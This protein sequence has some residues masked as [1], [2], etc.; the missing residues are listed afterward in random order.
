ML[1]P[2]N[3]FFKIDYFI[4]FYSLLITAQSVLILLVTFWTFRKTVKFESVSDIKFKEVGRYVLLVCTANIIQFLCYRM[5]IWFVDYYHSKNDVGLYA[6]ASKISQMW[7]V[8][9]QIFAGF[10]F[11]LAALKHSS[12][13]IYKKTIVKILA[14]TLVTSF[15][16]I[17]LYPVFIKYFV[18]ESYMG[19]F[20]PFVYL[21]PGVILFSV[22]ILLAAKFAGDGNVAVNLV[23]STICFVIVLALDILLIPHFGIKGAAIASSIAYTCSSIF[24]I[25]W[26]FKNEKKLLQKN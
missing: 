15:I 13:D 23:A 19:S 22:N 5:D 20:Y 9:P 16:A 25:L 3:C 1:N 26:F 4:P 6:F 7:W 12:M 8:L 18:G 2:A 24:A 10:F 21:L 11:P 17:L 14:F